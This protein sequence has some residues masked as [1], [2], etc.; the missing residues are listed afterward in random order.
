MNPTFSDLIF[1][2]NKIIIFESLRI[3]EFQEV[4]LVVQIF[5][6]CSKK[7]VKKFK[8]CLMNY[9]NIYGPIINFTNLKKFN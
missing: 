1:F 2:K 5:L 3:S 8:N 7:L 6:C 4:L 9:L